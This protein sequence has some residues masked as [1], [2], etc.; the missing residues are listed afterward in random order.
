MKSKPTPTFLVSLFAIIGVIGLMGVAVADEHRDNG[1]GSDKG[2]LSA[3]HEI[4][5]LMSCYA[6][7]FD[8]IARAVDATSEVPFPWDFLDPINN[9]DPNFAD[10]LQRFRDCTTADWTIE[11]RLAN[12][13]VI[14]PAGLIQGP[15]PWVNLVNNL[16]RGDGQINSQH[17]F[18][19]F[20]NTV[21]GKN[22]TVTAY[23][24]ITT[25]FDGSGL[26]P[27]GMTTGTS[28]Y[29]SDVVFQRG[30]WLLKKTTLI[31]N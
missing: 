17:L 9:S 3:Q 16:A 30:K 29:N 13:D 19:S 7:S 14:L 1:R 15:L 28:T 26:P 10:G 20:S 22:G 8:A 18:G 5:D 23:A 12:G 11:A 31:I 4:E 6:Y 24:L 25:Y 21:D 27:E 2:R